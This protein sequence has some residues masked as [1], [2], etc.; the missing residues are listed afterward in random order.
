MRLLVGTPFDHDVLLNFAVRPDG[1]SLQGQIL[2][3]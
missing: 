2:H 3:L 1:S